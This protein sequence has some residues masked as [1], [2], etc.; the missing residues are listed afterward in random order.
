MKKL[1]VLG[2]MAAFMLPIGA[3]A[4]ESEGPPPPLTDV[5]MVVPKAGMAQEFEA[6]IAAHMAF[7]DEHEDSRQ[8]L[9]FTPV[10][11]EKLG[12]YQFR[13]C[14]FNWA[15]QDAYGTEETDKGFN[16]NW[17][18]NVDQYVDHYH[19]YMNRTDWENSH[20]P[21]EGTSGPFYGVTTW[22]WKEDAPS[23]SD[24][25]REQ[26]SQLAK[27][28]GWGEK[29]G[30]WLWLDQIGGKDVLALVSPHANYADMAPPEQNFYKFASEELDSEKKA[31]AMFKN[32]SS[33]FASS[34]YTVWVHREELSSASDEE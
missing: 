15:D 22:V 32:F 20:W 12:I 1:I 8:W 18:E 34:D 29:G 33:G 10:I 7:R 11:G 19:H 21:D 3:V 30:P 4:Q 24:K 14:C 25:A 6:A 16:E 2:F 23:A 13:A 31:D 28:G 17:G 5:W 9:T 26:M 27:D